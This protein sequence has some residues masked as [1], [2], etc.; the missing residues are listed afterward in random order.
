M[1]MNDEELVAAAAEADDIVDDG[2][3]D[4]LADEQVQ[5]PEAVM[6]QAQ[7]LDFEGETFVADIPDWDA[8][9]SSAAAT[10]Q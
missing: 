2:V 9:D 5:V 3:S 7:S 8:P 1:G 4:V 10:G 6:E